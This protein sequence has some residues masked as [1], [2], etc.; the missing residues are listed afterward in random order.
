M[1]VLPA[2]KPPENEAIRRAAETW[3]RS[4]SSHEVPVR[5]GINQIKKLKLRM[6]GL[7]HTISAIAGNINTWFNLSN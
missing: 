6:P 7:V 1:D 2:S 3:M 5:L 4:L